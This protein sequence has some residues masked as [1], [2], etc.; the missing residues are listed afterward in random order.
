[1]AL[2]VYTRELLFIEMWAG[3]LL[4][5]AFNWILKHII[6]EERP[7]RKFASLLSRCQLLS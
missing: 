2:A 7:Y 1:M 5:E 3:Q 4:C 6:K